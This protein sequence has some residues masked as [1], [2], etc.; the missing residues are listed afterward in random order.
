MMNCIKTG[1]FINTSRSNTKIIEKCCILIKK[2][3]R[4]GWYMCDN[5]SDLNL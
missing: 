3:Y 1:V 2:L 4:D 5:T